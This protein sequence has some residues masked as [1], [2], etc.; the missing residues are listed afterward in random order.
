MQLGLFGINVS[1][2]AD[3]VVGAAVARHA[4]AAGF[5]SVWTGEHVV[6]P[7]PHQPPSPS[8]PDTPMLDPAVALASIAAQTTTIKL[9]TG[10]IILPQRNPLVLAKE[11]AS[12]DVVSNGRLILGVGGGYLHQEFAALNVPFDRRA[13]RTDDAM[14]A[15]EAIWTME[16]PTHHGPF[17]SFSDV[18]AMPRPVQQPIPWVMGGRGE[19]A[20]R[21]S[22][23]RC[24]GWYGF[25]LDVAATEVCLN[26]LRA[27]GE[28]IERPASLPRLEISIT[29]PPV[30][31]T[32]EMVAGYRA[33]GVDR[34]V[35][36]PRGNLMRDELLQLIDESAAAVAAA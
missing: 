32:P 34:I 15:M 4:E 18:L 8:K 30:P 3:P 36:L 35:V 20:Y 22:V 7:D 9:A 16:K 11:M 31:L 12:L 2:C 14:S 24:H 27:V 19:A 25:A 5:D 1:A 28:Q 21:R 23:R 17:W 10:I 29:P 33:L 26:E 13:G 6:L